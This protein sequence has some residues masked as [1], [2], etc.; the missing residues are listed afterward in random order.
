MKVLIPVLS[1]LALCCPFLASAQDSTMKKVKGEALYGYE[2][3]EQYGFIPGNTYGVMVEAKCSEGK[4]TLGGGWTLLS[5]GA[6]YLWDQGPNPDGDGYYLRIGSLSE[7]PQE[8]SVT[9]I[10]AF[11]SKKRE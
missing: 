10:C 4:K 8:V 7:E 6:W 1:V 2:S 5:G 9:A 11:V 3:I